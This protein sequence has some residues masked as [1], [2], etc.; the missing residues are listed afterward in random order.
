MKGI[1]RSGLLT[2]YINGRQGNDLK[3]DLVYANQSI[4]FLCLLPPSLGRDGMDLLFLLIIITKAGAPKGEIELRSGGEVCVCLA[5]WAQRNAGIHF[6]FLDLEATPPPRVGWLRP[7]QGHR[8]A[9]SCCSWVEKRQGL[10][11]REGAGWRRSKGHTHTHDRG[12]WMWIGFG[13]DRHAAAGGPLS[14]L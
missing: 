12:V 1:L 7:A 10:P 9:T 2:I 14:P 11:L 4:F 8:S 6:P 3:I 13:S 5:T